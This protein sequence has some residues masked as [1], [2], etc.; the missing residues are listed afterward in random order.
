[1]RPGGV[2]MSR[3]IER[4]VT[5]L[6]EPDS[7]TMPSVSPRLTSNDTPSTA[8]TTRPS[9]AKYV[10]K[11]AHRQKAQLFLI[12]GSRASRSPSPRKLSEKSVMAMVMPG[13]S[14]CHGKMA[15]LA[16][17][18]ADKLPHDASGAWTPEAEEGEER[19]EEHD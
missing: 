10:R 11:F 7:P 19:L 3:M 4:F 13:Q 8:F 2:G 16:M 1:M 5:D 14:S 12:C 17:P 18:S 9:S 15:M 6:P